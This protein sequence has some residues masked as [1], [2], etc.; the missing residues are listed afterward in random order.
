MRWRKGAGQK[1]FTIVEMLVAVAIA[2]SVTGTITSG[3][4][5]VFTNHA[6]STARMTAIKQVENSVHWLSR[7][8]QQAQVVD[9]GPNSGFPLNV[10][11][12][13][14]AGVVNQ[15]TYTFDGNDLV[16]T[17]SAGGAPQSYVVGHYI[18]SAPGQTSVQY[19]LGVFSYKITS[20]VGGSRPAVETREGEVL[21]RSAP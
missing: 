9:T 4:Y 6:R 5:Q 15:A 12:V 14:W 8:V 13:D 7:D 17:F 2:G 10:S 16:R 18:D 1:G 19:L 20:Y 21:P 11:W 3:F